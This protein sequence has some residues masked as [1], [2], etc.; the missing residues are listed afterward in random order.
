MSLDWT[1]WLPGVLFFMRSSHLKHNK[2]DDSQEVPHPSAQHLIWTLCPQ[3]KSDTMSNALQSTRMRIPWS[4]YSLWTV[5]AKFSFGINAIYSVQYAMCQRSTPCGSEGAACIEIT[6]GELGRYTRHIGQKQS[7]PSR[8]EE[9]H[10]S[11]IIQVNKSMVVLQISHIY[12]VSPCDEIN[13]LEHRIR[14][15]ACNKKNNCIT[16]DRGCLNRET[17]RPKVVLV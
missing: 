17:G 5:Y 3:K 1:Y 9:S 6:R 16:K 4:K 14:E 10:N 7:I 11:A 8:C 12:R 15:Y 13:S 2:F